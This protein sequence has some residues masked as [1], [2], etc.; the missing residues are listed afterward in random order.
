MTRGWHLTHLMLKIENRL[1]NS[2]DYKKK[3]SFKFPIYAISSKFKVWSRRCRH[4]ISCYDFRCENCLTSDC[5][6]VRTSFRHCKLYFF[7][8]LFHE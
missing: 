5:N 8:L 1:V 3:K 7:L 6:G 2:E 4:R